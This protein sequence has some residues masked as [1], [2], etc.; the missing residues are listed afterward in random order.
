MHAYSA[1]VCAGADI[2]RYLNASHVIGHTYLTKS[3]TLT[4]ETFLLPFNRI[5]KL[6]TDE[7]MWLVGGRDDYE[8]AHAHERGRGRRHIAH[9]TKHTH[10][11]KHRHTKLTKNIPA[12]Q[13]LPRRAD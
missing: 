4:A 13:N 8:G 5:H 3:K 12:I 7:E 1:H 9:G 10:T 6:L 2:V 11:H